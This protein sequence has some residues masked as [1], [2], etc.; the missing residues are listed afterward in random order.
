MRV[1]FA[2]GVLQI[3]NKI[4]SE[5]YIVLFIIHPYQY[6]LLIANSMLCVMYFEI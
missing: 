5:L 4:F 3:F 1:A 2:S 6:F